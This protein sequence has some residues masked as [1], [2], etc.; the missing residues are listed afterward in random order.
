VIEALDT[1]VGTVDNSFVHKE[2][3]LLRY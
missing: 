2:I 1:N 3:T